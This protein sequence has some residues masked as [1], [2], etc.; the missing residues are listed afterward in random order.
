VRER[1]HETVGPEKGREA[2]VSWVDHFI[3]RQVS[4]FANDS[5]SGNLSLVMP[6]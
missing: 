1:I 6:S 4:L 5:L 2:R 3:G